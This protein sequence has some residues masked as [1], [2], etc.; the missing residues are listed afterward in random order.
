MR[1][2]WMKF[3]RGDGAER[4]QVWADLTLC[5]KTANILQRCARTRSPGLSGNHKTGNPANRDVLYR[6]PYRQ[7]NLS[8]PKPEIPGL[9]VK[10]C[11]TKHGYWYQLVPG[12]CRTFVSSL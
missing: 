7:E 3:P 2:P 5:S 10:T 8:T 9:P 4:R 11:P 12:H 1:S 6:D